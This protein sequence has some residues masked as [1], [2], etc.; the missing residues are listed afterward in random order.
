MSVVLEPGI[1][2]NTLGDYLEEL[3]ERYTF[4]INQVPG[5]TAGF[6]GG[7]TEISQNYVNTIILPLQVKISEVSKAVEKFGTNSS[8]NIN[9][10]INE[11]A[12]SPN[13]L[14]LGLPA[15]AIGL[16]ILYLITR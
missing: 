4:Y 11:T 14:S 9:T 15:L 13:V 7:A 1:G 10:A 2:T 6:G 3:K 12:N 5:P 8:L 16:G